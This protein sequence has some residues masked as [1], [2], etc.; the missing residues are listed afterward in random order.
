MGAPLTV[1]IP[2]LNEAS[3]IAECVRGLSWADEVIVVDADSSD[4]TGFLAA[5]AGA[6]VVDGLEVLVAQG[7]ASFELWTGV[8]PPVEVMRAAVRGA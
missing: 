3:Q 8:P 7:A 5:A 6:R 1:V 2:T 4:G